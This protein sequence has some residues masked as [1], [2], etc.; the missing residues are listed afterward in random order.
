MASD[1]LRYFA[2]EPYDYL[3]SVVHHAIVGAPLLTTAGLD[4]INYHDSL[5]PALA[6]F[7]A[8]AH[9]LLEGQQQHGVTWHRMSA[10]VDR[11]ELL[12]QER[13]E[14]GDEDT[15]FTLSVKC[16]QACI[17]SFRVLLARLE[18]GRPEGNPQVGAGSFH[19]RSERPSV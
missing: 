5:L 6:G 19:V 4:A 13:F 17:E 18:Q 1:L 9:A 14:I 7:N 3:L 11:G 2:R 16:S 15:A 8:T 12:L 10:E